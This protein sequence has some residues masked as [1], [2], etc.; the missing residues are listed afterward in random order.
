MKNS[1]TD[2]ADI[3][4]KM[5]LIKHKILVLSGKGGVGKSTVSAQIS[6][7]L[8]NLGFEVPIFILIQGGLIRCRH[9]WPQ[10]PQDDGVRAT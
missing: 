4:S 1:V 7:F 10:Y 5:N 2:D 9:L 6:Y 3:R 8:A